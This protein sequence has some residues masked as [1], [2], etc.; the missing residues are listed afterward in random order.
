MTPQDSHSDSQFYLHRDGEQYGPYSEDQMNAMALSGQLLEND[1]A[2]S[3]GMPQWQAAAQLF[4]VSPKEVESAMWEVAHPPK[5]HKLILATGAAVIIALAAMV[6]AWFVFFAKD[7]S[8]NPSQ[9]DPNLAA[10]TTQTDA[11]SETSPETRVD[12]ESDTKEASQEV[13][14]KS[15]LVVK[16]F[17]LGMPISEAE[18]LLN[19]TLRPQ[20]EHFCVI[21]E[22][23]EKAQR[24]YELL[25]ASLKTGIEMTPQTLF[26]EKTPWEYKPISKFFVEKTDKG[27]TLAKDKSE[28]RTTWSDL[29]G[30]PI[31]VTADNEMKVNKIWIRPNF[32]RV[33]FNTANLKPQEFAQ[34]F[35]QGYKLPQMTGNADGWRYL[36]EEGWGVEVSDEFDITMFLAPQANQFN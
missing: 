24:A 5:K 8:A 32:T 26:G 11:S 16:G 1:L 17:Y 33:L 10:A 29:N 23:R 6:V 22:G 30:Y 18:K 13:P 34:Q 31:I 2:W 19:E 25:Q 12:S 21:A 27:Y 9:G 28:N 35:T 20:I 4:D 14:S 3:E 15:P 7:E 36:D